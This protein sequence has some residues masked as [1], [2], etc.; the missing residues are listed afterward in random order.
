MKRSFLIQALLLLCLF[1]EAQE[2]K[3]VRQSILTAGLQQVNEDSNF[4]LVFKGPSINYGMSWAMPCNYK[5]F[6]YEYEAGVS[7]LFTRE[8][9]GLG[10]YLKPVD[11][12]YLFRIPVSGNALFVGPGM[13]LE[14]LYNLYPDLQSAFDY[15]FTNLSF[16][17]NTSFKFDYKE[18]NF[19]IKVYSSLFGFASRHPEYRDPYFYDIG[20]NHAL[21]H[22]NQDLTFG[23]FNR[24]NA[25]E[26]EV[27]WKPS[28]TSRVSAG[29]I[30]KYKGHY[31][32]PEY[33]MVSHSIKLVISKKQ[34]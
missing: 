5:L 34:R 31:K 22:L 18:S 25:S 4:G 29:Y 6:T 15:W 33:T 13:K 7:V 1:G 19:G 11:I 23:T 12:S 27:L 28:T 26:L 16:G 14:Y 30:L 20:L 10:F 2:D 8:I 9:P 32:S 3:T 17:V 24:Y 21:R